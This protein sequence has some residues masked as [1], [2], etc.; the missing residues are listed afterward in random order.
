MSQSI[1]E[2]GE[3]KEVPTPCFLISEELLAKNL[4]LLEQVQHDSGAKIILALKGFATWA[5]FPQISKALCGTT[6]S[7]LNEAKLGL[8]KFGGEIHAY[9][10]AYLDEEIDFLRKHCH[11]I[12]LNS[13]SQWA[14]FR[15][16]AGAS[17]TKASFGLRINPEYS[18]VSTE[19]Y[20]PCRKGTRFGVT[21][22]DLEKA[23]PE[24]LEGIE[25]LHFHT[26]C[27]QNSDTLARTLEHVEKKFG[28]LLHSMKWLNCGGGHHITR[29]DYDTKLLTE[30]LIHL[31][32]TYN[33]EVYLEPGEAVVLNTG[34]LVTSV[35]DLFE[36]GGKNIA[37]LDTSATAHMPDVLEM[38]Y[39]PEI[40]GGAYPGEK[41]YT[42]NLGGLT[43][44]AGDIIGDWSF[45]AP[46][47]L[48]DRLVFK[49]MAHYTLVKTNYFNG[50]PHPALARYQSETDTVIVDKHFT[51][52]DF[53]NRLS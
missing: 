17:D 2:I 10:V 25:G 26:M 27:E 52:E 37:I 42:Y 32:T 51:Y 43:C 31:R 47:K 18:E 36:S 12:S 30:L 44:L 23:G 14:K 33:L 21:A 49:D 19:I 1:Q 20:N 28:H 8:E 46:L 35:V 5:T 6:A 48:G 45:D 7:S 38:P 40:I 9:F 41:H 24:I 4:S 22:A 13:L 15:N 50:V 11:H 29:P 3:R 39:R 34:F 53:R 16:H